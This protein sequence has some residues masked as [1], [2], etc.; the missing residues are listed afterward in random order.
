MTVFA[1]SL[2][3]PP[4]IDPIPVAGHPLNLLFSLT[5][6][7]YGPRVRSAYAG[8]RGQRPGTASGVS[9]RGGR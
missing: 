1:A 2:A 6:E 7:A 8:R 9:G 3:S 5:P 4:G